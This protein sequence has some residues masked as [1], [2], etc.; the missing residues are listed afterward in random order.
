MWLIP[1]LDLPVY[2]VPYALLGECLPVS[3]YQLAAGEVA[4]EHDIARPVVRGVPVRLACHVAV[5]DDPVALGAR[6]REPSD[7]GREV[8]LL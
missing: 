4:E 2:L 6:R 8:P 7:G 1:V 3:E 5:H